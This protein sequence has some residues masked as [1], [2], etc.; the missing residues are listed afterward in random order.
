M[1]IFNSKCRYYSN[2]YA[3]NKQHFEYEYLYNILSI[4]KTQKKL[5]KTT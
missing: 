4:L 5:S 3:L 2:I 1:N